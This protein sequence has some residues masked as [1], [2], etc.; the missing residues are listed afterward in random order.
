MESRFGLE[1]IPTQR[2]VR[3]NLDDRL[4]VLVTGNAAES[5]VAEAA[6]EDVDSYIL[7]PF[8]GASIRY[9]LVRAGLEQSQSSRLPLRADPGRQQYYSRQYEDALQTFTAAMELD[10]APSLACY[11]MGQ[12]Y[13]KLESPIIR[14]ELQ[15]WAHLQ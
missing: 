4:F 1:L 6:E 10:E 12:S 15:K 11:Y 13:D 3:P 2:E 9:Y 14:A 8:T 7:K 5:V